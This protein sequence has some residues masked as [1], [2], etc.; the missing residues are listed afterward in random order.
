MNRSQPNYIESATRT[1]ARD[2]H[3]KRRYRTV[4]PSTLATLAHTLETPAPSAFYLALWLEIGPATIAIPGVLPIGRLA[5]AEALAWDP[6]D[7]DRCFAELERHGLAVADWK[8]KLILLPHKLR[9]AEGSPQSPS[10]LQTLRRAFDELPACDLTATIDWQIRELLERTRGPYWVDLWNGQA[11]GQAAHQTAHQADGQTAHQAAGQA[12]GQAEGH[13]VQEQVQEKDKDARA[14][15]A[16]AAPEEPPPSA[17]PRPDKRHTNHRP[18]SGPAG[19]CARW[20]GGARPRLVRSPRSEAPSAPTGPSGDDVWAQVLA[21]VSV[22]VTRHPFL[23]WFG[24]TT[25]AADDG[26][27]LVVRVPNPE[28]GRWLN[29]HYGQVLARAFDDIGRPG[30]AVAF[31]TGDARAAATPPT[32]RRY[33]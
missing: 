12:A 14:T 23:T 15:R 1:Q 18:P 22:H 10:A 17:D 9:E 24:E 11:A 33:A 25:L 27:G 32:E 2:H 20:D 31:V 5:A 8:Q 26:A 29:K 6:A 13:Q 4:R 16:P 3:Q 30:C 21:R 19:W 28:T 7:F